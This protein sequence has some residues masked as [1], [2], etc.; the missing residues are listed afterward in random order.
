MIRK[1]RKYRN[2]GFRNA[3][4]VLRKKNWWVGSE[5][6]QEFIGFSPRKIVAK[7]LQN[8]F[9]RSQNCGISPV[10]PKTFIG[11]RLR[12]A[13][14]VGILNQ[15]R[16]CLGSEEAL[17]AGEAEGTSRAWVAFRFGSNQLAP[18]EGTPKKLAGWFKFVCWKIPSRKYDD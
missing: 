6:S 8:I 2:A 16:T 11:Q 7:P 14:S 17:N 3:G 4:V 5:I 10:D 1:V 12:S 18:R 9:I 13:E 15:L